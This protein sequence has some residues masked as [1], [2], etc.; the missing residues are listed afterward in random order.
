MQI[1]ITARPEEIAALVLALQGR[2]SAD[3]AARLQEMFNQI[4]EGAN[5]THVTD[6]L[7]NLAHYDTGIVIEGTISG[8]VNLD[9]IF[10][11]QKV[12]VGNAEVVIDAEGVTAS[13]QSKTNHKT[14]SEGDCR[15][16]KNKTD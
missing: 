16:I 6:E 4:T 10:G 2:Q 13:V 5:E 3:D 1:T 12:R 7:L 14:E 15:K 8:S 11:Q 9:T